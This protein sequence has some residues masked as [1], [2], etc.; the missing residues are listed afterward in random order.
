MNKDLYLFREVRPSTLVEEAMRFDPNS[1][2]TL[3]TETVSKYLI[4]LGQYL[5]YFK[6]ELNKT[7]ANIAKKKKLF[8]SS[9]SV[10]LDVKTVKKYG[11]K[12]A[13]SEY[14]VSTVDGLSQLDAEIAVLSEE[15]TYLDGMDKP[16]N[17]YINTFKRELSRREQELFTIRSER[18]A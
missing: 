13:A 12:K 7:K 6:S 5:I 4:A 1:L 3:S 14:L 11:T 9:L 10:S 18:R 17:E 15:L 16:I 8:E 2:E